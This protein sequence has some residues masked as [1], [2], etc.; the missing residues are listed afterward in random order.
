MGNVIRKMQ[1]SIFAKLL[2]VLIIACMSA[3]FC[4]GGLFKLFSKQ[5]VSPFRKNAIHYTNAII[6]E[7][8]VPPDTLKALEIAQEIS[9]RIRFESPGFQWTTDD[10]LPSFEDFDRMT[11]DQ[12]EDEHIRTEF[13]DGVYFIAVHQDFGRV[14][15]A[16]DFRKS[17]HYKRALAM[18]LIVLL[19]LIFASAYLLIR[20]ILKPIRWLTEGVEQVRHGDLH[21]QVHVEKWRRDE[22]GELTTSFNSMTNRIREMIRSKEQLLLDVSHEL[23]SPLTRI[24]VA[25][26]FVPDG[27]TKESIREDISEVETMITEILET[28]RLNSEHGKLYLRRTDVSEIIKEAAQDFQNKSPGVN[29]TSVPESVFLEI[30]TDRIK[31]VLKNVLENAVKY[32]KPKSPPVE[33]SVDDEEK[34]VV[35]QIKDYGSGIPKEELPYIFEPFYRTDKSRSKDTGGY[36]LGMSLCKKIMEAHGGSIEIKSELNVGTTVFLRFNK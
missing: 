3:I 2:F 14:L 34:C 36:G 31:T 25:L 18:L 9:I 8:G 23:R 5:F 33:I 27:P 26:E 20:R 16:F 12:N 13:D 22:L 32:S 29:L 11:S 17:A 6:R 15:F 28:E 21:Y 19:T 1:S 30:D 7:I 10:N 4:V 24:K 35:I